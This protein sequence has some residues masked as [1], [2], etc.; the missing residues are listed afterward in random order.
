MGTTSTGEL[1]DD[2]DNPA[3]PE[4]IDPGTNGTCEAR[5]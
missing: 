4:V 5:L 2:D 3:T 1:I